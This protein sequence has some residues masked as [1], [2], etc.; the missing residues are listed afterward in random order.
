MSKLKNI[1]PGE[2]LHED[3]DIEKESRIHKAD[4]KGICP[5]RPQ[6]A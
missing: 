4:L 3:F 5:F 1:H 2:T 6:A